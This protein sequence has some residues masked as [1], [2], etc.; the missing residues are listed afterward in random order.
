MPEAYGLPEGVFSSGALAGFEIIKVLV[1]SRCSSLV[2]GSLGPLD[3]TVGTYL[4]GSCA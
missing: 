1:E 4:C 3:P 2:S